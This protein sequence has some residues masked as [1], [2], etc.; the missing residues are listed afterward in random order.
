MRDLAEPSHLWSWLHAL[1][2]TFT[3]RLLQQRAPLS[4][5]PLE[6]RGIAQARPDRW[7]PCPVAGG[8]TEGQA[9]VEHPDGVLQVPLAEVRPTETAVGSDRCGPS[10]FQRGEAKRLLSMTPAL[11]EFPKHA[12]GPRQKRLGIDPHGCP[13]RPDSQS[14]ASTVRRST[15]AARPK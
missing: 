2:E 4:E 10:A 9:L 6:R 14:V 11:G 12:Q 8:T 13:G 7:Q 3:S 1:A 15:S 5:A